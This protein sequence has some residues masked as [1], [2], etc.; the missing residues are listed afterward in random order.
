MALASSQLVARIGV[1]PV[2]LAASAISAG[3]MFWLS[4]IT[5]HSSYTGGLLG[6]TLLT[7]AGLGLLFTPL[8]LTSLSKVDDAEAGLASSLIN[9]GQV[10]GGSIGLAIL[11]TVAWT[12]VV[13]TARSAA[14]AAG[15]A[16][17]AGSAQVSISGHAL[18][19]GFSR[20][21]EVSAAIMV[22]ALVVAAIMI[23]VTRQ[24]LTGTQP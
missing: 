15:N 8:T 19:A 7:G 1:R 18:A 3:G 13:N 22:L 11:G 2:V 14:H 21:F 9:T 16:A 20:G 10:V 12:V 17:H 23:R 24:D 6:P 5:E 4:R